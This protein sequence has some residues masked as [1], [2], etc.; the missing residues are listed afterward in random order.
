MNVLQSVSTLLPHPDSSESVEQKSKMTRRE[1]LRAQSTCKYRHVSTI[2]SK[3]TPCR[4]SAFCSIECR[5][6]FESRDSEASKKWY[7][8]NELVPLSK[9][10][11]SYSPVPRREVQPADL[12]NDLRRLR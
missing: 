12:E 4:V 7:A 2:L 6:S 5:R 9:R 8:G 10:V 11:N 1:L 3:A